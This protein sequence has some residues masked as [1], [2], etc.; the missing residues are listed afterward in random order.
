MVIQFTVITL[1]HCQINWKKS[2]FELVVIQCILL[3]MQGSVFFSLPDGQ[4]LMYY[5]SGMAEPPKANGK[6]TRDVPC[7]TTFTETLSIHN[8][9]K[10]AQRFVHF[11]TEETCVTDLSC[12]CFFTFQMLCVCPQVSLQSGAA[13]GVQQWRGTDWLRTKTRRHS[14]RVE[15]RRRENRGAAGAKV[16]S[17][18]GACPLSSRLGS[19]GEH[20]KLPQ[21][22]PDRSPGRLRF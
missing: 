9:L 4:G 7:K 3:C 21:R 10:K 14:R 17:G 1:F 2:N 18:E 11:L 22:G 16:R 19:L 15:R 13:E 6:I 20:R 12:I 8:W 5:V